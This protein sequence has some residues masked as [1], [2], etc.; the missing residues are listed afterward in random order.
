MP[1]ERNAPVEKGCDHDDNH[2][3]DRDN[4]DIRQTKHAIN[5]LCGMLT[6]NII[7][8]T[9]GSKEKNDPGIQI[10]ALVVPD[11]FAK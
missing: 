6:Y 1:L 7:E 4:G 3:A 10:F 2:D 11:N 5:K 9:Y 8:I